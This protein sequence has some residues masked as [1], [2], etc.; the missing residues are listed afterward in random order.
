[1]SNPLK[2]V[3]TAIAMLAASH[4]KAGHSQRNPD[5]FSGVEKDVAAVV[6]IG[7]FPWIADA[8]K[9]VEGCTVKAVA[10]PKP[11]ADKAPAKTKAK[12]TAAEIEAGKL[13]ERRDAQR[14]AIDEGSEEY[15]KELLVGLESTKEGEPHTIVAE[16]LDE[17]DVETL[18]SMA[19]EC[20][21]ADV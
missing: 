13:Q 15:L 20:I 16:D 7:D 11:E 9:A 1:M 21:F 10:A 19:V 6:V 8:Y 14:K 18:R 4:I 17:L 3:Y 12:P 5:Y 2:L